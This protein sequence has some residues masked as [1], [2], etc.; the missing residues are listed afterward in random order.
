MY[1]KPALRKN[2]EIQQKVDKLNKGLKELEKSLNDELKRTV[3]KDYKPVK[4]KPYK[5][6]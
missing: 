3:G 1:R 5:L 2:K 6:K 4:V